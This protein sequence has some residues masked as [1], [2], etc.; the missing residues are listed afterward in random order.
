MCAVSMITDHYRGQW[1]MNP[2]TQGLS[3]FNIPAGFTITPEQWAEYQALK[4]KAQEYDA[5]TNQ[6]D[7]AKP[8]VEEWEARVEAYLQKREV[9]N[10]PSQG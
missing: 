5:R 1:P 9:R 10:G 2:P 4:R 3:I 8:D 7:C 6:P